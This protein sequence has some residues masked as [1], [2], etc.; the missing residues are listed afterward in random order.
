MPFHPIFPLGTV[1][2][3]NFFLECLS[4]FQWQGHFSF[5]NLEMF[6]WGIPALLQKRGEIWELIDAMGWCFCPFHPLCFM[7]YFPLKVHFKSTFNLQKLG[8]T[9]GTWAILKRRIRGKNTLTSAC[10]CCPRGE[11]PINKL[12]TRPIHFHGLSALRRDSQKRGITENW[13]ESLHCLQGWRELGSL[14]LW[15]ICC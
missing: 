13:N 1:F 11:I 9:N 7:G 2:I 5:L 12:Q 3:G 10:S 6:Y 15:N 14:G 4:K 8:N